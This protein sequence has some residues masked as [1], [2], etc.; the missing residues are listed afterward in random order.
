[1]KL[2]IK[3]TILNLDYLALWNPNDVGHKVGNIV[4]IYVVLKDPNVVGHKVT[5][6]VFR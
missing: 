2:D 5:Y 3:L 4:F 1:M 6:I